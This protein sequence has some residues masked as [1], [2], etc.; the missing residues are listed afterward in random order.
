MDTKSPLPV[1]GG[2]AEPD[3]LITLTEARETLSL[4]RSTV[5]RLL[6]QKVLPRPIKV[7]KRTFFS[8]RE[9]QAWIADKLALRGREVGDE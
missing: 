7:G 8:E 4:S 5:Y 6:E 2:P 1:S 3:R 9:I